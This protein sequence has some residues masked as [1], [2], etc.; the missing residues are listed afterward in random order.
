MGT[1]QRWTEA[2]G[3]R[4]RQL[5]DR[6]LNAVQHGTEQVNESAVAV[7]RWTEAKWADWQVRRFLKS[8][9]SMAPDPETRDRENSFYQLASGAVD[10]FESIASAEETAAAGYTTAERRDG[11]GLAHR[12]RIDAKRSLPLLSR[13]FDADIKHHSVPEVIEAAEALIDSL[14]AHLKYSVT[15]VLHPA[16]ALAELHGAMLEQEME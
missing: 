13:A 9:P 3:I 14:E 5:V 12:A 8:H 11:R 7:K 1:F 16:D 4:A 2:A 10:D 15:R 6:T